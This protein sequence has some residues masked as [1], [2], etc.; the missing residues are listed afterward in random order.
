MGVALCA[1]AIT[2][3]GSDSSDSSDASKSNAN[4]TSTTSVTAPTATQL[5]QT[6]DLVSNPDAP[7][8]KKAAAVAEG[9]K[10]TPNLEKL[11][12]ALAGYRLTYA[13]SDIQ[14]Q[15][16]TARAQVQVTSPHGAMPMPMLWDYS[17]GSWQLSDP[18]TCQLLAMGHAP[19]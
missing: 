2:S 18:S 7:V 17:N 14:V 4:V 19:C 9:A 13:V 5:Q 3:C 16:S 10:R 1:I 15:G 8:A 6:L 11:T 12:A